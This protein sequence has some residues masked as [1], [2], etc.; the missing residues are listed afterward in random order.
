MLM[1]SCTTGTVITPECLIS[2]TTHALYHVSSNNITSNDATLVLKIMSNNRNM[3]ERDLTCLG[4]AHFC[5]NMFAVEYVI[6][7]LK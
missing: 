6:Y 4:P 1:C 3:S 7:L 2:L 5:P